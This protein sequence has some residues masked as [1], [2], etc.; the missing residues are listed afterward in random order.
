MSRN[1]QGMSP[2]IATVLL[3]GFTVALAAVVMTWGLDYVRSTTNDVTSKTD[4]A[5]RCATE[6]E[7]E[8]VEVDCQ[9]NQIR[10]QN[11]GAIDIANLSIL[12]H[13]GGDVEP[14][15]V[16]GIGSLGVK[17]YADGIDLAGVQKVQV[18]AYVTGKDGTLILCKDRVEEYV[19]TC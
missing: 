11:N 17:S 19:I 9:T 15:N 18:V 12:V 4:Q 2:L 6:L 1:K 8:I 3:I 5:L 7:F 13:K 14:I 10:V 16:A